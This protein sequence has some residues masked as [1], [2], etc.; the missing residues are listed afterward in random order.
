MSAS[1]MWYCATG[2]LDVTTG[3]NGVQRI[4]VISY[5]CTW[6]IVSKTFSKKIE[7]QSYYFRLRLPCATGHVG[8][9][10]DMEGYKEDSLCA[11]GYLHT[12]TAPAVGLLQV[13]TGPPP[14]WRVRLDSGAGGH[15]VHAYCSAL[16]MQAWSLLK[17]AHSLWSFRCS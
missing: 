14:T 3:G 11:G 8:K 15:P 16:W 17:G 9:P 5:N 4:S 13:G 6:I 10:A 1:W 12:A 2:K 7:R